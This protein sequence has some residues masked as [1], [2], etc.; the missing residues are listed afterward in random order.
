VNARSPSLEA[1]AVLVIALVIAAYVGAQGVR[2]FRTG[3]A[4]YASTLNAAEQR[5]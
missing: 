3:V 4:N 1:V 5:P 2:L